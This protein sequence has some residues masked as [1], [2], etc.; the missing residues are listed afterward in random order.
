MLVYRFEG[1]TGDGPYVDYV[2]RQVLSK[3]S[4][5]GYDRKHQPGPY[6][7]LPADERGKI[8]INLARFACISVEQLMTWW[9]NSAANTELEH[10]GTKIAIYSVP[11]EHLAIG[12]KQVAFN[13]KHGKKVGTMK[14]SDVE[15][16]MYYSCL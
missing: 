4:E 3:H 15:R 14:I 7:D 11:D 1:Q 2:C 8:D 9:N 10:A 12:K 13:K 5:Y 6:R 16:V